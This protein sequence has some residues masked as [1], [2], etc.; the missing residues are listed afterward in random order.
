MDKRRA[1]A[2]SVP[3]ST[4]A[5]GSEAQCWAKL[6]R[7]RIQWARH[8]DVDEQFIETLNDLKRIR[9]WERIPPEQPYGSLDA[10]SRAELGVPAAAIE[11]SVAVFTRDRV[12]IAASKSTGEVLQHGTNQWSVDVKFLHPQGQKAEQSGIT[13]PTQHKLDHLA[14]HA[15]ELL[16][17]VQSGDLS[18]D[19]AYRKARGKPDKISVEK[20]PEAF[21]HAALKHLTDDQIEALVEM[22]EAAGLGFLERTT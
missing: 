13:R 18:A 11:R 12:R 2:V 17:L 1:A 19:R 10:M 8:R 14:R 4:H 9:A 3:I 7:L 16:R 15:P 20:T 22:L 5:D 6:E 21:A